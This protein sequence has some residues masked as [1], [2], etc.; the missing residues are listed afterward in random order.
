MILNDFKIKHNAI[1]F[2]ADVYF[3]CQNNLECSAKLIK[4]EESMDYQVYDS[5]FAFHWDT[6]LVQGKGSHLFYQKIK[7]SNNKF[8]LDGEVI[9]ITNGME[10]NTPPLFSDNS[11]YDL[12]SDGCF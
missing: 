9:D 12:S 5:L 2:S 11:N 8:E 6:W 10:L 3:S 1:V 4:K 7:F